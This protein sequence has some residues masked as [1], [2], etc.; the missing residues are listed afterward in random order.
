MSSSAVDDLLNSPEYHSDDIGDIGAEEEEALLEEEYEQQEQHNPELQD[1]EIL[2]LDSGNIIEEEG[3]ETF[4]REDRFHSERPIKQVE[5]QLKSSGPIKSNWSDN[6]NKR[7]MRG[8]Y[9]NNNYIQRRNNFQNNTQNK[10][11]LINPHF[12]GHVPVRNNISLVWDKNLNKKPLIHVQPWAQN[13]VQNNPW[14]QSC[15]QPHQQQIHSGYLIPQKIGVVASAASNVFIPP[16]NNQQYIQPIPQKNVQQAFYQQPIYAPQHE[17]I[18]GFNQFTQYHNNNNSSTMTSIGCANPAPFQQPVVQQNNY[19]Q[20]P[21]FESPPKNNNFQRNFAVRGG[22]KMVSVETHRNLAG[23]QA[24]KRF[25]NKSSPQTRTNLQQVKVADYIPLNTKQPEITIKIEKGI[26][27]E[28]ETVKKYRLLIEEQKKL[29]EEI[30]RRKEERRKNAA[31]GGSGD[32]VSEPL[33]TSKV[34]T[35]SLKWSKTIENNNIVNEQKNVTVNDVNVESNSCTAV[36]KNA[37]TSFL[38]N[39]KI[40]AKDDTLP[41]TSIVVVSNLATGSTEV[42]LRKLCKGVGDVK[43]L[44]ISPIERQATIEFKSVASAH[45][46][47]KKYQ[48]FMLDL[49]MIQVVLKKT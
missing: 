35:N 33:V 38:S 12:K 23:P 16:I 25:L 41:D 34:L 13:P 45:T 2:D 10:R 18:N 39:R 26:E 44:V 32:I 28:D 15:Q 30:L 43:N 14:N 1:G 46:F 8:G 22:N 49:S 47:Y 31:A 37:V 20:Q 7:S 24:R 6:R 4:E 36:D 27:E 29:R 40:I 17:P 21:R 3:D 48:R 42:K 5:V 19:I 11:V 9:R